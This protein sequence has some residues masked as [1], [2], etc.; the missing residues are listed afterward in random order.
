M[1]LECKVSP[2]SLP[3][4][5]LAANL[6]DAPASQ[7]PTCTD[8]LLLPPKSVRTLQKFK[9]LRCRRNLARCTFLIILTSSSDAT[10]FASKVSER[11]AKVSPST[12][13]QLHAAPLFGFSQRH[14]TR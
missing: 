7:V 10:C 3:N 1:A 13:L 5:T 11:S 14:L 6:L 12:C 4:A 2:R 9:S 8:L